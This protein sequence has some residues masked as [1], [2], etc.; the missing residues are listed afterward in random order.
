MITEAILET[1]DASHELLMDNQ[2]PLFNEAYWIDDASILSP[3]TN[4]QVL[5][6]MLARTTIRD[7]L[8]LRA[9]GI[10][11]RDTFFEH[12]LRED[13][14]GGWRWFTDDRP[15]QE[16]LV[17]DPEDVTDEMLQADSDFLRQRREWVQQQEELI[18]RSP[19][20]LDLS[21]MPRFSGAGQRT[22]GESLQRMT[23]GLV[24]M[25]LTLGA[26]LLAAVA[27]FMRDDLA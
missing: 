26:S 2:E 17:P 15:G 16:G 27:R 8:T 3:V 24:V 5:A 10:E 6:Y 12:L 21:G 18:A 7:K 13:I 22:L 1:S 25:L 20:S 11:Y 19:R 9:E 4:F 14:I 23:P